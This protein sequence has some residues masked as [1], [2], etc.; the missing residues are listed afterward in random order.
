MTRHLPEDV[1]RKQIL[2][3]ARRCFIEKGYFPTRMEDI[4]AEA[5][6]SKGGIYFHFESKRQIFETLVREEFRESAAF[7]SEASRE[8][9]DFGLMLSEMARHYLEFFRSR[10]D[11][12]RFFM[13]MGEMA[14]RDPQVRGMLAELQAEYTRAIAAVIK[15]GIESGAVRPLDA[16]AVAMLL[17]GIVDALE[18]Y[19]AIGVSM[20]TERLLSVGMEM[21]SHGLLQ[22]DA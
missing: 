2:D 4:A 13:V 21:L 3:A 6:L 7:L 8:E 19:M 14:G 17:K 1:R 22:K 5:H 20:D 15:K 11:Y 12:P 18:G 9:N 10:P 16:E